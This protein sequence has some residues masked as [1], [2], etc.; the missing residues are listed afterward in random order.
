MDG[1]VL[2][3]ALES[4][5][6]VRRIASWGSEN[7]APAPA[8]QVNVEEERLLLEQLTGLGYQ[9]AMTGDEAALA[10]DTPAV[11]RM[12]ANVRCHQK[13]PAAAKEEL[14]ALSAAAPHPSFLEP[15]DRVR[16]QLCRR[17]EAE[18]AFRSAL[19]IGPE[20]PGGRSPVLREPSSGRAGMSWRSTPC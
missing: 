16:L 5:G 7:T 13:N 17:A 8:V 20:N 15:R 19:A 12:Q 1:K 9:D 6:P 10:G 3:T 14:D 18:A 2:V 4:P 11:R